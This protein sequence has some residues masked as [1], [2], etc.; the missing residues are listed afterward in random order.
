MSS[1]TLIERRKLERL[2]EMGGG[3]VLDFSNRTLEEFVLDVVGKEI[4]DEKYD[5]ASGS[6]ANRLRAFWSEEPDHLTA[7]LVDSLIEY[8]VDLG[9]DAEL[10]ESCR[11]ISRRL[12]QNA[13]VP[14]LEAIR[15]NADD[16]DFDT[17]ADAV[18][19][20]IDNNEPEAGL[21]RLHTFTVRY[22][23]VL[24]KKR[25]IDV[26]RSKPLHSLLGELLKA[27]R[28]EGAVES[29]MAERIL[30]SSISILDSFNDVRNNRSLAHDNKLLTYAEALL[31]FNSISS[32]IR[33][34]TSI[35]A[36]KETPTPETTEGDEDNDIPF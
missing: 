19:K 6:K 20:S 22:L 16:P 18:R 7:R 34:L 11:S 21:D 17:L 13:P 24:C 14:D 15:P 31:I 26:S 28:A 1:I 4:Y 12:L 3:Y 30:R 27:L 8:A 33:F 25:E 32:I 5:Y 35:E 2:L 23:R 10:A 36:G 9:C 29:Q